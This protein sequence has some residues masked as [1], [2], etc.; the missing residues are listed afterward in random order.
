MRIKR[1]PVVSALITVFVTA[2]VLSPAILPQEQTK[3]ELNAIGNPGDSAALRSTITKP[4]D[5]STMTDDDWLELPYRLPAPLIL[6]EAQRLFPGM[7]KLRL[8]L[9]SADD[10]INGRFWAHLPVEI[11]GESTLVV[12]DFQGNTLSRG[13][14]TSISF[15]MRDID[16]T[17]AERVYGKIKRYFLMKFG[18][19]QEEEENWEFFHEACY[20]KSEQQAVVKNIFAPDRAYIGW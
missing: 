14:M 5:E 19:C 18:E 1:I 13:L 16:S 10:S 8:E 15:E 11:F 4:I 9:G 17:T 2:I 6:K 3:Q 20:W 7:G 12:F